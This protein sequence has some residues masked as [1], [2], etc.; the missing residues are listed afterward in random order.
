V[1]ARVV[2]NVCDS[3]TGDW[4]LIPQGT[5]V[6][7]NYDSMVAWGQERIL[8]CWNELWLPN[9][10]SMPLGCMPAADWAGRAGLNDLVDE[11]WWRIVQGAAVSSLLT[12]GTA[13]AAGNTTGFNPTLP[14]LMARG[15]AS[16]IGN[17]GQAIT[18]RN[19]MIQPT[20]EIRQAQPVN[21]IV[22]ELLDFS[23][24][25]PATPCHSRQ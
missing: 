8:M 21:I 1:I 20:L 24:D 10:D 7:A 25:G 16:E 23:P 4:L 6:L 13:A 15:A 18:R 3:V 2:E 12:A 5:V 9:S 14:Q 17:A 11:H 22:T 19:I